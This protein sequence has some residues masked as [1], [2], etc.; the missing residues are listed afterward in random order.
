[1]NKVV[2]KVR[3]FTL[4]ELLVVI[5]II[6]LLAAI[7][8]PVFAQAREKARQTSCLSNM[9]QQGLA[10]LGYSQDY[11][12]LMP[13]GNILYPSDWRSQYYVWTIP[14]TSAVSG[15]TWANAVQPYMKNYQLL[16]CPSTLPEQDNGKPSSSYTFNG[17]LQSYPQA[18]IIMP[19]SVILLWPGHV[20]DAFTGSVYQSPTLLCD[21]ATKP[22]VYQPQTGGG[23]APGNGGQD[24]GPIVFGGWQSY[25]KWVHGH[26]DNF[27]YADGH[28]KWAP[29]N[30]D[31]H[32][33]PWAYTGADGSILQGGSYSW[34]TDGC[35]TYLFTP[36]FV[37]E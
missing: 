26:G 15:T 19:S 35:H 29:L 37:P 23:C 14:S 3:A 34:W 8:F 31:W 9:K 1:M 17:D 7:L 6:A 16:F 25:S 11:D 13:Q 28:A 18:G 5:A 10:I 20:K 33:D 2:G 21:D 30:G 22:C 32:T 12:E 36:D 4:I 24:Q 27:L